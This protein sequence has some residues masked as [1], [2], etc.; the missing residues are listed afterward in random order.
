[1]AAEIQM[2]IF[3]R[4]LPNEKSEGTFISH[5]LAV[6]DNTTCGI[7]VD[8]HL[9]S[10]TLS[11]DNEVTESESLNNVPAMFLRF[12]E[13]GIETDMLLMLARENSNLDEL[14]FVVKEQALPQVLR[15]LEANSQSLGLPHLHV[16]KGYS[17]VSVIARELNNIPYLVS[18]IFERLRDAHLSVKLIATSDLRISFLIQGE[19]A[20]YAVKVIHD[21]LAYVQS[22]DELELS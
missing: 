21:V 6:L 3:V 19:F 17:R 15:I 12:A 4:S 22:K 20:G 11:R 1:M 14:A 16:D 8:N 10:L 13:L 9:A 18:E 5:R 7:V 2:P